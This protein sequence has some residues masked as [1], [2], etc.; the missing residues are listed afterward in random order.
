[1]SHTDSITCQNDDRPH[2]PVIHDADL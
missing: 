1:V 2:T